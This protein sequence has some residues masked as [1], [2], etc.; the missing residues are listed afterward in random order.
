MWCRIRVL[1]VVGLIALAM[2]SM[3]LGTEDQLDDYPHCG[4][5]HMEMALRAGAEY[6]SARH[7]SEAKMPLLIR[8]AGF[9]PLPRRGKRRCAPVSVWRSVRSK[10]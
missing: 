2:L 3:V 8:N 9:R 6:L 1:I 4:E 5:P 7:E 10:K